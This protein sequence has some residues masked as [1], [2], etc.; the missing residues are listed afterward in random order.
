MSTPTCTI[1]KLL[2]IDSQ[3]G[4][5]YVLWENEATGSGKPPY[6][7]ATKGQS[8]TPLLRRWGNGT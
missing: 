7:E 3:L 2:A 8:L 4:R 1:F 6:W 5:L